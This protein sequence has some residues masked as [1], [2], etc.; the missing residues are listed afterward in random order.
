[1]CVSGGSMS[2]QGQDI[3]EY[4]LSGKNTSIWFGYPSFKYPSYLFLCVFV[5]VSCVGSSGLGGVFVCVRVLGSVCC[6][7]SEPVEII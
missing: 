3:S 6:G 7:Y 4:R 5:C 2:V 1:M